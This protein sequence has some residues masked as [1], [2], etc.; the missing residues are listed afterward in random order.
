MYLKTLILAGLAAAFLLAGPAHAGATWTK[1]SMGVLTCPTGYIPVSAYALPS[2]IVVPQFCVMK[3]EAK[4]NPSTAGDRSIGGTGALPVSVAAGIPWM[5]LTWQDA[6]SACAATGS[7]L[8]TEN[9]WLSLAHQTTTVASNWTSG[10]VGSGS[11]FT[12]H[13]DNAPAAALDASTDDAN[14]YYGTGNAPG[15]DQRR[16]LTL[17]NG[18]VIWDLS[19]NAYEY[20]DQT[21]AAGSRYQGGGGM[22]MSFN[23]SE[24]GLVVAGN[25]PLDKKPPNG[26]NANQGMGRYYDG[27]SAAG[28]ANGI[29]EAPENCVGFCT[30]T[31]VFVRS[32]YWNSA[33]VFTLELNE[34]RSIVYN[35]VGFRCTR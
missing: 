13:S 27:A 2:G 34:G 23:S 17:P 24:G 16:T 31:A 7:Q 5:F 8:I 19:G 11:L 32:G 28:A 12:G 22:W 25:V 21:I 30:P 18:Q 35:S 26:W 10:V 15:S 29:T 1:V 4:K 20:V 6:R 3:Y 9:Q 33:G 14:G